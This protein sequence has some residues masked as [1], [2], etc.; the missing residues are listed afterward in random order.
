MSELIINE[1]RV[2]G[3]ITQ[4]VLKKTVLTRADQMRPGDKCPHPGGELVVESV[5]VDKHFANI[6][7]KDGI[8]FRVSP[9]SMV[10]RIVEGR[11]K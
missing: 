7:F 9:D 11:I 5:I 4:A 10:E 1:N 6:K 3:H 8:L 2:T